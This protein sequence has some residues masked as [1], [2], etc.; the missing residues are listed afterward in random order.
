MSSAN[1]WPDGETGRRKGLKIPREQSHA[2]SIPAPATMEV[3][4]IDYDGEVLI[5]EEWLSY[6]AQMQEI[7]EE[8]R[9]LWIN[10][11]AWSD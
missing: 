9:E 2:G 7:Y 5:Y 6:I 8:E 1:L 3:V 11:I 10:S 4:P